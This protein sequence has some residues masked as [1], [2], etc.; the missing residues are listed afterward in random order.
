M[1]YLIV[2]LDITHRV[3]VLLLFLFLFCKKVGIIAT[4][5]KH[6]PGLKVLK[7]YSTAIWHYE[8]QH[9][10]RWKIQRESGELYNLVYYSCK[11]ADWIELGG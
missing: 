7:I 3:F 2:H 4:I 11:R 10:S 6:D 1:C 9:D 5:A 8:L